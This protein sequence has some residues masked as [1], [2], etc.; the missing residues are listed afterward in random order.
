MEKDLKM[1]V[2]SGK[3]SSANPEM[4]SAEDVYAYVAFQKSKKMKEKAINHNITALSNLLTFVGN[5]AVQQFRV[6]YPSAVP[7]QRNLRLPTLNDRDYQ[8][9]LQ[10]ARAVEEFEWTRLEAYALVITA[11]CTGMRNKE[12]RL[13]QIDDIDSVDW[14]FRVEHV[15]GEGTYGQSRTVDIRP[16]AWEILNKF[17]R[18]RDKMVEMKCPGNKA[19][20]PAI[21][22]PGDGFFASNSV[23]KLKA[24]VEE[25]TGV[26][27]DLRTCR[28]TYGQ[29]AIDKGL[30]LDSVSV[31]MGHSNTKTTEAYYCRKRPD[32]A[33]REAKEVFKAK[34]SYPDVKTPKIESRF[35]VTGYN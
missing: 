1:L 35:E 12:I 20:F 14:V 24:L 15:K 19:L 4:M 5:P 11:I 8:K 29:M 6:K 23:Q 34:I 25:E 13:S 27:F 7:K 21:Q 3:V 9:I 33:I 28:R 30:N 22:D 26:K 17:L 10:T 31:L 16:D 2:E 32:V 18:V